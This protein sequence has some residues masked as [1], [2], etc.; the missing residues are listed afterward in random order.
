MISL[1]FLGL[2]GAGFLLWLA[3]AAVYDDDASCGSFWAPSSPTVAALLYSAYACFAAEIVV[4]GAWGI[5]QKT[6]KNHPI[7]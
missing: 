5:Y 6:K 7:P 2:V 4:L 3:A 1:W